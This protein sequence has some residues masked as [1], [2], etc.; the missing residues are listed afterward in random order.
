MSSVRAIAV[1]M[2]GFTAAMVI[3]LALILQSIERPVAGA[4]TMFTAVFT[5]VNGLKVGDDV[6]MYGVQVGKVGEILLDGEFRARV[7]FT[8]QTDHPVDEAGTV[9]IRF[10]TLVGQRYVDVQQPPKASRP[11]RP[12]QVIGIG[13]TL[14]SFDITALFNGLQP[15]LADLSPAALNHFTETILAVLDGNGTGIGPALDAIERL[16]AY[17]RDR[18][19]VLSVLVA[20]LR[21]VADRLDARSANAM[22]LLAG[23]DHVFDALEQ[24]MA[25]LI[26]FVVTAPSVL[27]PIDSLAATLGLTPEANPDLAQAV[28]AA[29]PD[30]R[31][32]ADVLAGLPGLLQTLPAIVPR[33]GQEVNRTCS[34]GNADVPDAL[35]ILMNGQRI[36]L[37]KR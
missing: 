19:A 29:I 11:Q 31:A 28:R 7:R 21:R 36:T 32:A 9:A 17:V 20:N 6:R 26:D 34:R 35:A 10:Q 4:D 1:R 30:P 15:V 12:D 24:R 13:R 2:A 22:T 18:Q 8:V 3:L 5:D 27:T 37:C 33:T 16:S 14:G 25:G 23:L